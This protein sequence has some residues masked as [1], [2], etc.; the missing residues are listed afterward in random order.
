MPKCPKCGVEIDFLR[1]FSPMWAE[2]KLSVD[3][4]GENYEWADNTISMDTV[5]HEYECPECNKVLF[6]DYDKAVE[7]L[8]GE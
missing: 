4:E 5:N 7:F 1:D 2:Y 8:K 3:D 6:E